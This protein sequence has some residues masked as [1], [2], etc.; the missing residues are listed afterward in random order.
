MADD[1][2]WVGE[3]SEGSKPSK[4]EI[5]PYR[6]GLTAKQ[7]VS[8]GL[9]AVIVVFVLQNTNSANLHLLLFTTSYP[10][11]M[12]LGGVASLGFLAGWLFGG[13]RRRRAR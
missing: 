7:L 10:L 9:I 13:R 12:V 2:K 4:G 11:W 3:G 8:G 6:G 1:R 5:E